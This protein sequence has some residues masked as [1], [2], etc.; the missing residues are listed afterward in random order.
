MTNKGQVLKIKTTATTTA[1]SCASLRNDKQR[2]SA[3]SKD[4]C[5]DNRRFLRL[6]CG[7]T[8]KGQVLK[9]KTTAT[10]T[11]DSCASLRNDKQRASAKSKDNCN[12][13]RRFL[14]FAAE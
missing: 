11:A 14:R 1:D 10:T 8:N 3:K 4:N 6:R 12:D 13:N 2:A 7:M 5:N 9:I